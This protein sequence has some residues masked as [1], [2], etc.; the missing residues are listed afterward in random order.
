MAGSVGT[1]GLVATTQ[2]VKGAGDVMAKEGE[3][4]HAH[5]GLFFVDDLLFAQ[6]V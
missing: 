6:Y 4:L 2:V 1:F 3:I 5:R